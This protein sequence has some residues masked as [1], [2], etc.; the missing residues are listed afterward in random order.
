[1][2]SL[3]KLFRQKYF[4]FLVLF[5]RGVLAQWFAGIVIACYIVHLVLISRSKV[6]AV[7]IKINV[8]VINF[9]VRLSC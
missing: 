5:S 6:D 2:H 1:M 4:I 8:T 9:V 7:F 3:E